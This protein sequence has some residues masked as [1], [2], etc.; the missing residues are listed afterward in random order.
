MPLF[1][2]GSVSPLVFNRDENAAERSNQS[3]YRLNF[4]EEVLNEQQKLN[5]E[6]TGSVTHFDASL[7]KN[8]HEQYTQFQELISFLT[9]QENI[10]ERVMENISEQKESTSGIDEKL[11]KLEGMH[12]QFAKAFLSKE[13]TNQAILDQLAHQQA[14]IQELNRKLLEYE[15]VTT[16]LVVQAKKQEELQNI[17][18][19]H[20]DLQ[21]IFHETI[22][23]RLDKQD[24]ASGTI[25]DQL[26]EINTSLSAKATAIMDKIE[27]QY[28]KFTQFFLNLI[29][30]SL[31]QRKMID[32]K[33]FK[34]K[35]KK[36]N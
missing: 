2:N 18:T 31:S 23:E 29:V 35:V 4:L 5:N 25:S 27:H 13:L 32:G 8:R 7:E 26:G 20:D 12:E 22:M 36:E 21:G 19:K 16:A 11:L 14:M 30:P 1:V 10:S 28:T 6:L 9:K 24:A 15:D 3:L 34:T 17:I 33:T